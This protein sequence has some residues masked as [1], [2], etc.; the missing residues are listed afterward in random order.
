MARMTQPRIRSAS[1]ISDKREKKKN[2]LAPSTRARK[3]GARARDTIPR[4]AGV[5]GV[6]RPILLHIPG[7]DPIA[8]REDC[9]FVPERAQRALD[10]FP[11][12]L[13]HVKGAKGGHPF[14]LEPWQVSLTANIFGWIRPDGTRRYRT[15]FLYVPRKNGKMLAMDTPLPTPTGWTTIGDV[16]VGDT[17]FDEEGKPCSVLAV[18]PI[19]PEPESY[20]LVFSNGEQIHACAEH[21]WLTTARVDQPGVGVGAR[22]DGLFRGQP[23]PTLGWS[24]RTRLRTTRE[25]YE[26]QTVGKRGDRNHAVNMPA[27]LVLPACELPIDPYVLGV[28]LG[29]GDAEGARVTIA[30]ADFPFFSTQIPCLGARQ[31]VKDRTPRYTLMG[32]RQVL[33]PLLN[34]KHIPSIYLRASSAQRLALLQ[35]LMDT[36]GC[37]SKAGQCEFGSSNELLVAQ[38]RELLASLGIKAT[39]KW[40][41]TTAKPACR[42]LF[43]TEQPVFRMPRKLARMRSSLTRAKTVQIVKV[44]RIATEPMRCITV[45][46][47]SGLYLCGRTMIPTHNTPW[48]AGVLLYLLLDDD[49]P[50]MELYSAATDKEQ[51]SLIFQHAKGMVLQDAE[52]NAT[53]KIYEVA[54]SIVFEQ[55]LSSYKVISH[56]AKSKHGYNSHGVVVDELH[57]QPDRELVDVLVTSTGARRQP[58]VMYTTTSDYARPS[59]CN[60]KYEYASKVRD[61]I[62]ADATFLPVIYEAPSTWEGQMCDYLTPEY[63]ANEA[64]WRVANPN[65]GVSLSLEYMRQQCR[66]AQETP[67]FLNTFLRLHLNIRTQSDVA[68]YSMPQWDACQSLDDPET[69][70]EKLR[71]RPCYAGLD[72]ASTSDLCALVLLFPEDGNALLAYFWLP[73]DTAFIRERRN[74]VPYPAWVNQGYIKTTSGNVADYDQIREDILELGTQ[75]QIKELAY[76]RWNATHLITQLTNEGIQAFGFGQGFASMSAPMKELDKY[77][78]GQELRHDGNPVARWCMSNVMAEHDAADNIKPSKAKSSEKIDFCVALIMSIGRAIVREQEGPSIYETRGLIRV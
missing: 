5:D 30:D 65:L 21:L 73:E 51:A 54:K 52:L 74:N 7:Y 40:R 76:D 37:V 14:E 49:E 17:L 63:Y 50:G 29:D 39:P 61:G 43:F 23:R 67:G 44:Q 15:V 42:M 48:A 78:A 32:M 38:V 64:I 53:L 72:L 9:L 71:G 58:L 18:H 31:Q 16:R 19:D 26:T 20:R 27:P 47:P 70:R 28:W 4:E 56:E 3:T 12:Y 69:F 59:I 10:F 22:Q 34:N 6:W 75:Y 68:H 13:K 36:D 35:G 60:E 41:E 8:T 1:S 11:G 33:R 45:S 25:I 55:R 46:S 2:S 62:L 77:L 66:V 57:A 24:L